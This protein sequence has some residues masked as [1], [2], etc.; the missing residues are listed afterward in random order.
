LVALL[1]VHLENEMVDLLVVLMAALMVETKV[2]QWV[3]M[4][5]MKVVTKVGY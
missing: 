4:V 3:Q 1:V 2:D 5:A